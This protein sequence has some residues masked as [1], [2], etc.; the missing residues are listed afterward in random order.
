MNP[1]VAA[2]T[3]SHQIRHVVCA[4]LRTPE[5]VVSM[6][7]G[8]DAYVF[9]ARL[10][11]TI[12]PRKDLPLRSDVFLRGCSRPSLQRRLPIQRR[13]LHRLWT[14]PSSSMTGLPAVTMRLVSIW[15]V[16]SCLVLIDS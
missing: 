9:D 7:S 6:V 13:T 2:V 5:D 12:R 16:R 11:T 8:A 1:I 15:A 10:A 3:D 14:T 4:A